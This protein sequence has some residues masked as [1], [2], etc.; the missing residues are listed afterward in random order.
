MDI[1]HYGERLTGCIECNCWRGEQL[2]HDR[3]AERG[4]GRAQRSEDE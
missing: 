2:R 1:D 4:C 3:I